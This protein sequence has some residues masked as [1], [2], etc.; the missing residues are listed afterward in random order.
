MEGITIPEG[1]TSIG[2]LAFDKCK[3]ITHVE[4]PEGVTKIGVQTFF[5]CESLE[6]VTLPESLTSIGSIAFGNC[7]S[8]QSIAIPDSVTS[9]GE[10]AFVSCRAL[11]I[12]CSEGSAA[13]SYAVENNVN[14]KLWKSINDCD[15]SIEQE[16]YHI[17]GKP[18]QPV[19]TV[20]DGDTTLK[21]GADYSVS[22]SNTIVGEAS[23]TVAG[24]GDYVG[25]TEVTFMI[26]DHQWSDSYTTDE[27]ATC[28]EDGAES[29]YCTVC[30]AKKETRPIPPANHDWE[31]TYTTDVAATCTTD[32]SESIHC[33]KCDATK[34]IRV[35]PATGH[36]WKHIKNPAGLLKNGSEY[37][38]CKTCGVKQ[39]KVVTTGYA[40]Y[41]VDSFK[42]IGKKKAFKAEWKKQSEKNQKKFNGYQIRY[43][44]K[45]DMSNAKT[46]TAKNSSESKKI[47]ELKKNKKYYV[48]V[49]TYT[50][51]NGITF[52]SKWS[53]KK[54]VKTK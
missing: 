48:Q 26:N 32:G 39:N 31:E 46:A 34:D 13:H 49:R 53:E 33:R 6:R 36:D 44:T 11:C 47:K 10:G 5:G 38:Q 30:G 15:V 54:A 12:Y 14:Y 17:T 19:I 7:T 3:S 20:K 27:E 8:L 50:K 35:I 37:D 9:I 18:I 2:N 51:S 41:Y 42:V 43:S 16:E 24:M 25:E 45:S 52:Y 1:V 4:I 22:E 21:E 40:N 23:V 28:T 29:I